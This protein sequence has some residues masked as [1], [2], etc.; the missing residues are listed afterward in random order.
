MKLSEAVRILTDAGVPDASFDARAL[1]EAIGGVARTDL[2]GNDPQADSEELEDAIRRRAAREP[3]QYIL[4]RAYFFDE[5]YRV[6]EDCLIPR[7][8]TEILVEQVIARLPKGKRFADLCTGS[9]CVGIS[10]LKHTDK[11]EA[12]LVDISDGALKLA[13]ENARL[14][15]VSERAR[16]MKCDVLEDVVCEGLFAIVSNPPYVSESAYAELEDEIYFEPRI[17]FVGADDGAEFYKRLIPLYR[18]S[19][20]KDGFMA[21]EIGYDQAE[22]LRSLACENSMSCEIIKDLSGN[23]RVAVLALI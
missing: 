16:I 14:N 22:L 15:S 18:N 13:R 20:D 2:F 5:E 9:G 6:T 4:G 19:I 8:D 11:T 21:F 7:Q 23:D 3:L 10:I 12:L 17:A 1:F